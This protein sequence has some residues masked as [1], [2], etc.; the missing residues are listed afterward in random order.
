MQPAFIPSFSLSLFPLCGLGDQ[1]HAT[2]YRQLLLLHLF[3]YWTRRVRLAR[4][5]IGGVKGKKMGK[6]QQY[7]IHS[8]K[9]AHYFGNIDS[10][11]ES[12]YNK[13]G[14]GGSHQ[15]RYSAAVAAV[16]T[17]AAAAAASDAAAADGG[18][19]Y[20]L[21]KVLLRASMGFFPCVPFSCFRTGDSPH[22]RERRSDATN[23]KFTGGFHR[24]C[25]FGRP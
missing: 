14:T 5:N 8:S 6:A 4:K 25:N 22:W 10:Q 2:G 23:E 18:R 12:K 16:A 9:K 3:H 19:C 20:L 15:M 13:Q 7:K 24:S 11:K 1:S 17:T 21:R